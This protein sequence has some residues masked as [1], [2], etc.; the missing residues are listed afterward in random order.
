MCIHRIHCIDKCFCLTSIGESDGRRCR[1]NRKLVFC[2]KQSVYMCI[3]V[4]YVLVEARQRI[5]YGLQLGKCKKKSPEC[6]ID[7]SA[8]ISD[9]LEKFRVVPSLPTGILAFGIEMASIF[10]F[11]CVSNALRFLFWCEHIWNN[12]WISYALVKVEYVEEIR[13]RLQF[14][15]K[16]VSIQLYYI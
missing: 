12:I 8:L 15:L 13:L 16:I 6:Y 10:C 9:V 7:C 2:I 14:L 11:G 4:I 3:Y 1:T 5:A